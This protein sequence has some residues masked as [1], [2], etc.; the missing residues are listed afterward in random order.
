M[1]PIF[2]SD[3]YGCINDVEYEYILM[4]KPSFNI[5]I[6][7]KQL[8]AHKDEI[9]LLKN[10]FIYKVINILGLL[11]SILPSKIFKIYL[12]NK[13]EYHLYENAGGSISS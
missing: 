2:V 7:K 9:M 11:S 5:L 6:V 10:H 1:H 3:L 13:E 4:L 12:L 8:V